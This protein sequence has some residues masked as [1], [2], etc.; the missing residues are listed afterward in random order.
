[1]QRLRINDKFKLSFTS[2]N[3]KEAS[4]NVD[5][6]MAL[7]MLKSISAVVTLSINQH[8]N[9]RIIQRPIVG[10]INLQNFVE[11][12]G[13]MR[14]YGGLCGDTEHHQYMRKRL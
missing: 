8:S 1:M 7:P 11:K 2:I 9:K 10:T 5:T 14:K 3:S 13:D 6:S 4:Y 12:A